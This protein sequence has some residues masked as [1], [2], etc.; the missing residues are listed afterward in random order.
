MKR[1][2]SRYVTVARIAY[3][4]AKKT[5]PKYS[6]SK[7]K[8]RYT[9]QQLAACV[10][11]MFYVN[12][13][14]RDMEEWLLAS[15]RVLEVLEL[16]EVPNYST[17]Q[18]TY[19]KLR[20]K[21]L[22]QMQRKLLEEAGPE[23][24]EDS[25][26]VDTTG[27]SPSQASLH[28]LTRSGRQYRAWVKGAYAVGTRSQYIL[29]WGYGRGPSGDSPHLA[30]LRRMAA[31]YGRHQGRRR[32]WLLLADRGFEDHGLHPCDLVPVT[33][34]VG[35]HP[36]PIRQARGE[37]VEQARL[38]GLFGQ[39]WKVETVNSVIKR[40]FG[41]AIRSRCIR[42]QN[43]EPIVKALVYNIHR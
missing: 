8:H 35:Q 34:R 26:A 4:L 31:R 11:V 42:L 5:L 41:S 40:K 21:D 36:K 38:D 25:I 29:A 28:Y 23:E 12:K 10:L 32:A 7:S 6:H 24:A 37:L 9:F 27:F 16:A 3:D 1:R 33:H 15:D 20:M 39:R 2:E 22:E 30:P 43:R 19:K 14:Y 18:R 13:S 17:L